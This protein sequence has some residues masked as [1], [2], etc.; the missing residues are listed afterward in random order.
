[1]VL[2]PIIVNLSKWSLKDQ[3]SK[4]MIG[5]NVKWI[6]MLLKAKWCCDS[7]PQQNSLKIM[8]YTFKINDGWLFYDSWLDHWVWGLGQGKVV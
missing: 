6:P 3:S 7:E 2:L 1:M 8:G 4:Q 5:A